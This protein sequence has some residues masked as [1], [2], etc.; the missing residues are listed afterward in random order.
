MESETNK[1]LF[2]RFL[3]LS[4]CQSV[5]DKRLKNTEVL[6]PHISFIDANLKW[7]KNKSTDNDLSAINISVQVGDLVMVVGQPRAGK[8]SIYHQYIFF[9]SN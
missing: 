6:Y 8:V 1:P 4:E 2:Q 5:R 3:L 9:R 7:E